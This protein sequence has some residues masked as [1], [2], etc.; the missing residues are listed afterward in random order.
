M[1]T[2]FIRCLMRTSETHAID[3]SHRSVLRHFACLQKLKGPCLRRAKRGSGDLPIYLNSSSNKNVPV[4]PQGGQQSTDL[5][6]KC[7]LRRSGVLRSVK[8]CRSVCDC[9]TPSTWFEHG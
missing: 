3:S 6:R 4:E 7:L 8:R 2:P 5:F 1:R 9:V